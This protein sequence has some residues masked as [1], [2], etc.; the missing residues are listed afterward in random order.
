MHYLWTVFVA[1]L[2]GHWLQI[3]LRATAAKKSDLSGIASLGQFLEANSNSI[4]VRLAFESMI[5]L[6]WMQ[7]PPAANELLQW[8]IAGH[9]PAGFPKDLIKWP[10]TAINAAWF[11]LG[12][13]FILDHG[14]FWLSKKYPIFS[15]L[16]TEIP[17]VG[18][19][20]TKETS[21]VSETTS[22]GQVES[23]M[24]K[25]TVISPIPAVTKPST[26]KS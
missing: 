17:P 7:Y 9:L 1:F 19:S 2:L 23:S 21:S 11:G 20:I 3:F 25:T 18:G 6:S 16:S 4:A 15:W 22:Q 12:F 13:D 5:M 26:G 24:V 8:A 10:L 14:L